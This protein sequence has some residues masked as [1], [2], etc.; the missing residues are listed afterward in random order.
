MNIREYNFFVLQL[1]YFVTLEKIKLILKNIFIHKEILNKSSMNKSSRKDCFKGNHFMDNIFMDNIFMDNSF[2]DNEIELNLFKFNIIYDNNHIF[3]FD[4]YIIFF[5]FFLYT[6][7]YSQ[8]KILNDLSCS[9]YPNYINRF[10]KTYNI[11]SN[12]MLHRNLIFNWVSYYYICS[13]LI[14]IYISINWSERESWDLFGI[15]FK[16][17]LDLRRI[18][19]D[20]G[21]YGHPFR[22]DFPLTGFSELGFSDNRTYLLYQKIKLIQEFRMFSIIS[23]WEFYYNINV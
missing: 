13:T 6:S 23:P 5:F 4:Y 3:F 11:F 10:S 1:L 17:N 22:K 18:L 15:Y 14:F 19:N 12:I 20:Y 9:D 2:M 8:Y 16:Y 7:L 21:F